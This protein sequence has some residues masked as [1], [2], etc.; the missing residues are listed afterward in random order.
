VDRFIDI[1][2]AMGERTEGMSRMEAAEMAPR[3]VEKFARSLGI[4][5]TLSKETEDPNLIPTC[6]KQALENEN[7]KGN[8]RV[9]TLE[10]IEELYRQAYRR[11]KV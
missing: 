4:K 5:T 1:A 7:I 11:E 2:E 9:P 3:S 6:A 10:E 8:P